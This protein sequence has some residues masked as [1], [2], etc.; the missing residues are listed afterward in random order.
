MAPVVRLKAGQACGS[1]DRLIIP[2]SYRQSIPER[3]SYKSYKTYKSYN[4]APD[5]LS[6]CQAVAR[7][8]DFRSSPTIGRARHLGAARCRRLSSGCCRTGVR[9]F[10]G[11]ADC[12]AY[13]DTVC[14]VLQQVYRPYCPFQSVAVRN[15]PYTRPAPRGT[16]HSASRQSG[17]SAPAGFCACRPGQ[18]ALPRQRSGK[19]P[20]FF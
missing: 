18:Y 11:S 19:I 4:C 6:G 10:V 3:L 9:C 7:L 13:G 16:W 14:F 15:R 20:R 2:L 5:H 17:L 12:A 8:M 1:G